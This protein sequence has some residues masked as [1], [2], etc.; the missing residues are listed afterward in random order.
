MSSF[1]VLEISYSFIARAT[2]CWMAWLADLSCFD[3]DASDSVVAVE[4]SFCGV[5]CGDWC[6]DLWV[7]GLGFRICEGVMRFWFP[8]F[9]D[10]CSPLF[11]DLR[12][13]SALN[14]F[15]VCDSFCFRLSK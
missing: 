10:C 5:G 13:F 1:I 11:G 7:E 12:L 14:F 6:G 15:G 9:G 8:F 3:G 2:C 4:S